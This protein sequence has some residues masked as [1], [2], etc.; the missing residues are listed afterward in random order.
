[1]PQCNFSNCGDEL[2]NRACE[3]AGV[4]IAFDHNIE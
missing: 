1:M 4:Y 3:S 2:T